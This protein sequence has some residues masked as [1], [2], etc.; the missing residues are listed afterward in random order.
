W[1]AIGRP[2]APLLDQLPPTHPKRGP[3]P[4]AGGPVPIAPIE[5]IIRACASH[6]LGSFRTN[7]FIPGYAA[8]NLIGDPDFRGRDLLTALQGLDARSYKNATLLFNVAR[9]FIA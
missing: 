7:G 4:P 5:R 2:L 6:L 9:V 8:F 3:A 1:T